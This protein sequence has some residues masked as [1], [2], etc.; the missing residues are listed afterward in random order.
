M[1]PKNMQVMKCLFNIA[2]CLGSLL[3]SSWYLLLKN[4]QQ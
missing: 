3:G 4:F 2:Y 1:S